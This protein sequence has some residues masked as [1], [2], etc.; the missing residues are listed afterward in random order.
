M[1]TERTQLRHGDRIIWGNN[2][3]FRINCPHAVVPGVEEEKI[4]YDFAQNELLL[5]EFDSL[6]EPLQV[7]IKQLEE[8]HEKEKQVG[9]LSI[10]MLL[11]DLLSSRT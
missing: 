3:F 6:N 7:V 11:V 10:M 9:L 5:N 1:V 4:D 2:H 8:H